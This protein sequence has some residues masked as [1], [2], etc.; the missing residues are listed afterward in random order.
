[1]FKDKLN[2]LKPKEGYNHIKWSQ[3]EKADA[4]AIT[5]LHV[6]YYEKDYTVEVAGKVLDAMD[7]KNLAHKLS[8]A[9]GKGGAQQ[10]PAPTSSTRTRVTGV[11]AP[12]PREHRPGSSR[13][14]D[15][16]RVT[17]H[18]GFPARCL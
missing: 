1:M 12:M 6:S 17:R 3:L 2:N 8:E 5:C 18:P 15:S 14:G 11:A 13:A 16:G 9:A 10:T 7:K 4:V